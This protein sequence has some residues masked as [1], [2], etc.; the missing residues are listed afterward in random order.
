MAGCVKGLRKP[1]PTQEEI[2]KRYRYEDGKLYWAS[3]GRRRQLHKP[4]GCPPNPNGY[5]QLNWR[6]SGKNRRLYVHRVIWILLRG[7]EPDEIDHLNRN[8]SDNRIENLS[9]VTSTANNQRARKPRKRH[10]GLPRG[11]YFEARSKKNPYYAQVTASKGER[12]YLGAYA[13]KEEAVAAYRAFSLG[14][15]LPVFD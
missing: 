3:A 14:A 2:A 10:L 11:V 1:Y 4:V 12:I 8:R 7:Y 13:T 15:G 5:V 6:E 9:D